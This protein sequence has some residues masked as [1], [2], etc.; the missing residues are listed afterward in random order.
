MSKPIKIFLSYAHAD[1][2]YKDKLLMH[3]KPLKRAGYIDSW[4]DR[5]II[6]GQEWNDQIK[7]E[8]EAAQI[9]LFLVSPAFMGSDYIQDVE[10][11]KALERYKDK[12]V[13]IIP[14]ILHPVDLS[15]LPIKQFQAAPKNAKPI[16]I[17]DN[18]DLAWLDVVQQLKRVIEALR[19]GTIQLTEVKNVEKE[20]EKK[21]MNKELSVDEIKTLIRTF[22]LK[23]AIKE[24]E[25]K[26]EI[27]KE[28]K[29]DTLIMLSG[30]YAALEMDIE[31]GVISQERIDLR[32]N[33]IMNALLSLMDNV[34]G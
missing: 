5:E 1:E 8:L 16:T 34:F 33:Q 23:K 3:L 6:L 15:L 2:A 20:E 7:D 14:V 9:L 12:S 10:I 11:V 26:S 30:Q 17:W 25:K 13:L 29:G 27:K 24:L 4:N 18:E 19:N 21:G 31:K 28:G 22:Q 32:R